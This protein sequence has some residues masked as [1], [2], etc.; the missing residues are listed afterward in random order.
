MGIY[1]NVDVDGDFHILFTFFLLSFP[2]LLF[3]TVIAPVVL[4]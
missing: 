4:F 3:Y 2:I 1:V